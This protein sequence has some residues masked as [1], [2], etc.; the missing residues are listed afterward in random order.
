MQIYIDIIVIVYTLKWKMTVTYKLM[1]F[2]RLSVLRLS[3]SN[4]S[5]KTPQMQLRP[6]GILD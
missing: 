2:I 1:E 3:Y 6:K 4:P 5:I